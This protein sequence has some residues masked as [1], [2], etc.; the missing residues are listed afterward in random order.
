MCVGVQIFIDPQVVQCCGNSFC[1]G[2]INGYVEYSQN[3]SNVD[4]ACPKCRNF[5]VQ[6]KLAPVSIM[7]FCLSVGSPLCWVVISLLHNCLLFFCH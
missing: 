5:G 2:C 3:N 4:V 7:V 6:E 1:K